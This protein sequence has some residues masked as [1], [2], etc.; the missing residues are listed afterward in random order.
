MSADANDALNEAERRLAALDGDTLEELTRWHLMRDV[1]VFQGK[2]LADGFHDLI[3]SPISIGAALISL[4]KDGRTPGRQF[5]DVLYFGRRS[6][7]WINLFGDCRRVTPPKYAEREEIESIDALLDRV[8]DLV[9]RQYEK[10][11]ITKSAKEA[12]DSAID[13]VQAQVHRRAAK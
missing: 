12:I 9:K 5:Y 11:G 10:G 7:Q 2:L 1:V 13:R 3:L 8:D 4:L 6:E